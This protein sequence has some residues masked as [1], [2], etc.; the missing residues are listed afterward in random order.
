[1]FERRYAVDLDA[2]PHDLVDAD[3][4]GHAVKEPPAKA[5][6]DGRVD[7]RP[8]LGVVRMHGEFLLP[9]PLLPDPSVARHR[10]AGLFPEQLP[11]NGAARVLLGDEG[12]GVNNEGNQVRIPVRV[13]GFEAFK[14]RGG[15]AVEEADKCLR[16]FR[17]ALGGR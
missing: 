10:F 17:R 5:W 16:R 15:V 1:M 14:L 9:H 7:R 13:E 8:E 2:A 11:K 4:M 12:Q 3:G 6:I